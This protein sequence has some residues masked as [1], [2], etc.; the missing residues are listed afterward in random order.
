MRLAQAENRIELLEEQIK[1]SQAPNITGGQHNVEVN[2]QEA[3][4]PDLHT[5]AGHKILQ[6]WPRLRLKLTIPG[7]EPFSFLR[8]ADRE[9]PSLQGSVS[10]II[11]GFNYNALIQSLERLY[12]NISELPI[13]LADLFRTSPC[14]AREHIFHLF[15]QT[16]N[17][18]T[19]DFDLGECSIEVLLVSAIATRRIPAIP[20]DSSSPS[21][22]VYFK[23]AL[24]NFWELHSEPSQYGLSLMLCFSQIF[25]YFFA[26]PFHA[27]GILQTGMPAMMRISQAKLIDA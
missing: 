4:L 6:Y 17:V 22:E 26:R 21:A 24:Q 8:A 11:H 18:Q 16:Q 23:L 10:Q 9:D 12:E 25:L 7:I 19:F 13:G 1:H 15:L 14:F 2:S 20:S 27:L 3:Q 5:A